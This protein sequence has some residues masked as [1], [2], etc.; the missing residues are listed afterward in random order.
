ML[1]TETFLESSPRKKS[2]PVLLRQ[3]L[4]Q[5]TFRCKG[6]KKKKHAISQIIQFSC[7]PRATQR[8]VQKHQKNQLCTCHCNCPSGQYRRGLQNDRVDGKCEENWAKRV[9]LL[10]APCA[11]NDLRSRR[12]G[13]SAED[14]VMTITAVDPR[15][16]RREMNSNRPQHSQPVDQVERDGNVHRKSNLTRI[17]TVAV[18]PLAGSV[19]DRLASVRSLDPK[20]KRL[21]N[22]TC[23]LRDE[24]HGNLACKTADGLTYSDRPKGTI[25]LAK[26]MMEAP[27]TYGRTASGTSP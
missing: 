18:E 19:D 1:N 6:P 13:D 10:N 5:V 26:R 2:N 15:S 20:L 11:G 23:T 27:Q 16:E 24:I 17:G 7:T 21:Q 25:G 12:G 9:A 22:D 4:E 8:E 3:K 14:A